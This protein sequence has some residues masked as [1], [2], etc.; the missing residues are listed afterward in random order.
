MNLYKNTKWVG[1]CITQVVSFGAYLLAHSI[2]Q[3]YS[4]PA[5]PPM[6]ELTNSYT[7]S[8]E[9]PAFQ[10]LPLVL[11]KPWF[12]Q[13]TYGITETVGV[14]HGSP[15]THLQE[16]SSSIELMGTI[17]RKLST[18]SW[19]AWAAVIKYHRL[20]GLNSRNIFLTLWMLRSLRW[21]CSLIHFLV[22]T[23]FLICTWLPSC[24][25]LTW[26]RER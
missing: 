26:W 23:C 18:F 22:S 7:S 25:A 24:C 3:T 1:L 16:L 20:D 21:G 15:N 5:G 8:I 13:P 2:L 14:L 11:D 17:L 19:S 6:G 9:R 10:E 12:G 4:L